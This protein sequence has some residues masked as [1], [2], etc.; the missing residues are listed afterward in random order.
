MKALSFRAAATASVHAQT[1][2]SIRKAMA[3][4]S[5]DI[6]S[7]GGVGNGST[8]TTPALR[9]AVADAYSKGIRTITFGLGRFVFNTPPDPILCGMHIKGVNRPE[10][11]LIRNYSADQRKVFLE[12][13]GGISAKE[14]GE[15]ES[16]G[17]SVRQFSQKE[18]IAHGDRTGWLTTQSIA[19]P[20]PSRIPC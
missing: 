4:T 14:T 5:V 19:N 9:K 15:S 20:S 3:M 11:M 7:Y 16:K 1:K 6:S 12:W 18:E 8:D 2:R 13:R 17:G 10:T